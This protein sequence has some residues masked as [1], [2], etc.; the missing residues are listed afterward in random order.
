MSSIDINSITTNLFQ[1]FTPQKMMNLFGG[2]QSNLVN[3]ATT[4]LQIC[5]Y[6]IGDKKSNYLINPFMKETLSKFDEWKN[7]IPEDGLGIVMKFKSNAMILAHIIKRMSYYQS[8]PSKLQQIEDK[9]K[10]KTSS[11]DLLDFIKSMF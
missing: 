5:M 9:I 3:V 11:N 10:N 6:G 7:F 8:N 1:E 2:L 4:T